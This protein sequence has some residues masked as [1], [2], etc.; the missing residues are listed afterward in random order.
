MRRL[1]LLVSAA[2]VVDTMFYSAITPLLADYAEMLDIS[3]TAAGVLSASYAAGTFLGALPSGWLAARVGVRPTLLVGLGLTSVSCIVFGFGTDLVLLD[4]ARFAQGVGGACTWAGA[5]A[6]LIGAAPRERRGELLGGAL[7]FA[8]AG[9]LLGPVVGAA[10]E[11][12]G[13]EAVFSAVAVLSLGLAIMALRIDPVLPSRPPGWRAVAA[14]IAA[15]AVL[16]AVWLVTLPSLLS[17]AINVLGP[18]RLDELGASA[19]GIGAI[20]LGAAAIEAVASRMFGGVSDRRGRFATM[21]PGIL[22]AVLA[23][24][25]LTLPGSI[26]AFAAVFAV[27]VVALAAFWAPAMALLSDEAEANGLDMGFAFALVNLAW[28][29]GQVV[30]GS[31]GAGL[32]EATSDAVPYLAIAALFGLTALGFA[33]FASPR[34]R[35]PGEPDSQ[36]LDPT[37]S[38][39]RR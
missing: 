34:A 3:K 13:T 28:A 11:R 14:A 1:F 8:I 7:G 16:G 32:A 21:R 30:G 6:W 19:I 25:A 26:A 12:I 10:A 18:L 9:A 35:R 31:A 29:G 20:F 23:A 27:T 38:P 15:P 36:P 37:A 39:V 33:R 2:V 17:G 22:L 5:L 24:V 4:I